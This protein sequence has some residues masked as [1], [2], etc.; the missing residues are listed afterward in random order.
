MLLRKHQ[1]RHRLFLDPHILV[2][3]TQ[4]NLYAVTSRVVTA[5]YGKTK[6][7]YKL[8]KTCQVYIGE[9]QGQCV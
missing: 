5:K 6:S 2:L 9:L 4:I 7:G 3:F 1:R 8:F